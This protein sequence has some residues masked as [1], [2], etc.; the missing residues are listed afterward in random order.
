MLHFF[1]IAEL[2]V[3]FNLCLYKEVLVLVDILRKFYKAI[4]SEL[5]TTVE[6]WLNTVTKEN[7]G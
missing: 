7:C 6:F 2:L 5:G 1:Y 4:F 3:S